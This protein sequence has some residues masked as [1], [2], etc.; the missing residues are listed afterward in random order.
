MK[1]YLLLFIVL[2]FTV[3]CYCGKVHKWH[4]LKK[5]PH[6]RWHKHNIPHIR[7]NRITHLSPKYHIAKGNYGNRK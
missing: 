5:I 3:G 1:K 6:I 2:L 4:R 7:M